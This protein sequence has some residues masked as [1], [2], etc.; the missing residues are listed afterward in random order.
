MHTVSHAKIRVSQEPA[1][2]AARATC[3]DC[4]R[5]PRRPRRP[6]LEAGLHNA[7]GFLTAALERTP[8][9]ADQAEMNR[10]LGV[11]EQRYPWGATHL[12]TLVAHGCLLSAGC[13]GAWWPA[14][15]RAGWVTCPASSA[16]PRRPTA[17]PP[18]PHERPRIRRD[19]RPGGGNLPEL[20]FTIFG[21]TAEVFR[22]LR[23]SQASLDLQEKYG[24]AV[25]D[26]GLERFL[27][28]TRRQNF[29]ILP[30]R[31]RVFPLTELA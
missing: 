4:S 22:T 16:P 21:P 25:E 28:A 6:A 5:R 1:E 27:T 20:Q 30:R 29:I 12:V 3:T 2:V 11:L 13:P 14:T 24:V 18:H 15:C 8:T 9:R 23:T 17:R 7:H 26:N 31:Q 19:G 10:A